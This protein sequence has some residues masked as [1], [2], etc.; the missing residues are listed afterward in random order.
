MTTELWFKSPQVIAALAA[1]VGGIVG[2]SHAF[3][4]PLPFSATEITEGLAGLMAVGGGGFALYRRIKA[5]LDPESSAPKIKVL[6][7]KKEE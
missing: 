2:F 4:I 7:N 6:P 5:G 1:I 3:H